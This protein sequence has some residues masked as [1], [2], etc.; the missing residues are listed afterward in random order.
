[1][2]TYGIIR[3]PVDYFHD[4]GFR[5]MNLK[6]GVAQAKRDKHGN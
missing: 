4:K 3:F 5:C 1:M 6:D 2:A